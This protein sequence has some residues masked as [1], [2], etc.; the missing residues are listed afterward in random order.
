MFPLLV[1]GLGTFCHTT[2]YVLCCNMIG[3]IKY[4]ANKCSC[5]KHTS[6]RLWCSHSINIRYSTNNAGYSR[7]HTIF[8]QYQ[9]PWCHIVSR[10]CR[11]RAPEIGQAHYS[12]SHRHCRHRVPAVGQTHYSIA[13]R[14]CRQWAPEV[15]QTHYSIAHRH[16]R[17]VAP[18]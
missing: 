6:Q 11:H 17:H 9:C 13:H 5:S 1:Q 8:P 14:Q 18:K 12:I 4:D 7:S 3:S 15:G 10:H 2:I 16:C